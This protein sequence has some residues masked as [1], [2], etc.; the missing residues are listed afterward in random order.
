MPAFWENQDGLQFIMTAV[1]EKE[2]WEG[3]PTLSSPL[4]VIFAGA[5]FCQPTSRLD[6]VH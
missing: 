6:H 4:K 1:D 5:W 2:L 3:K